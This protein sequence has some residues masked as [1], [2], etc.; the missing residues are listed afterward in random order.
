MKSKTIQIRPNIDKTTGFE[1][2]KIKCLHEMEN[3][4]NCKVIAPPLRFPYLEWVGGA[5]NFTVE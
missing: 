3:Y 2:T 1:K 5:V 4:L